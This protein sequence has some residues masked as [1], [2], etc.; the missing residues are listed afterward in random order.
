MRYLFLLLLPIL[1][2]SNSKIQDRTGLDYA[3]FFANDDYQS[4]SD[5]GNLNNPIK[6]ARAIEKE[7]KEVFGFET[8]IYP[9]LTKKQIYDK[10]KFW[11]NKTFREGSQLLVFFSGHGTFDDFEGKGFFVPKGKST[12]LGSYIDLSS[13]GNIVTQ[14]PCDH[15]LLA[16][17]ACYSGTI[18]QEIAMD[19]SG[20]AR[21]GS[22]NKDI[23]R[24]GIIQRQLRNK[25]RLLITSGG[26]ERT[27]D[28]VKNSPFTQALLKGLSDAYVKG[29]GLFIWPELLTI[30]QKENPGSTQG[31]LFGHENGGFVFVANYTPVEITNTNRNP[32]VDFKKDVT[33]SPKQPT[34]IDDMVF[35]Q[36]GTFQMGSED[37][38]EREKPVHSVTVGDFYLGRH[39]VTVKEYLA[40]ANSVNKH[41][42]EWMEKGS[43]YNIKT[44][45]DDHYKK[46]GDALTNDNHPIVGISWYDA[47]AYCNWKSE[48]DG[49]QKVYTINSKN[50]TA[51]WNANGYRLPTEAE[52]EFAARSRGKNQKWAGTSS[53]AQ[54]SNYANGSGASDGSKYTA[55]IGSF[56]ANDLGIYDLSGNVRE[57][58]WDWYDDYTKNASTNPKGP[59]TGAFRVIR[60]GSWTQASLLALC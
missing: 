20:F 7:L 12:D 9:N 54:L 33:P 50:I 41:F 27:S 37:G 21:P 2:Q 59:N 23:K 49:F 30:L 53:E 19:R 4:N 42:P 52:W 45:S 48:Q 11:R 25:S 58:C 17:D 8:Q 6:D 24:Q 1:I 38:Y 34:K 39:E 44:G 43:K 14:I 18:D 10:L 13:L 55:P 36:D 31:E 57:W 22:S 56:N 51:N 60:G 28:G 35:V 3:I 16:I 15:I 46:L 40:F 5:F 29:N 47:V 32:P 26:K